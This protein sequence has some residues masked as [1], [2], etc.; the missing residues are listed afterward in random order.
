[1]HL[2]EGHLNDQ[3]EVEAELAQEE[4]EAA[5]LDLVCSKDESKTFKRELSELK[6]Q[7]QRLSRLKA[8]AK[9]AAVEVEKNV[10]RCNEPVQRGV[11]SILSTDW[12]IKW[13][14]WH[15]VEILRNKH[16]RLVSLAR[17]VF[18][19]I[20]GLLLDRL[21]TNGGSAQQKQEVRKRRGI[22]AK[23]LPLFDR[24]VSVENRSQRFDPIE[25][26]TGPKTRNKSLGSMADDAAFWDTRASRI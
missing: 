12:N 8:V 18:D 24:L 2:E 22:V 16:R 15:G 17:L 13:P 5:T 9:M 7:K 21:K 6:N 20:K 11:E 23:A 4:G 14:S 19:Q 3:I 1:V 26:C 25:S 10:G